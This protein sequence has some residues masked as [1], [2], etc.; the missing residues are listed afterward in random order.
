VLKLDEIVAL[1]NYEY[2]NSV[3]FACVKK[4]KKITHHC[5]FYTSLY[6]KNTAPYN[7]PPVYYL[8]EAQTFGRKIYLLPHCNGSR[9]TYSLFT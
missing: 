1:L 4:R 6:F 2:K 5:S 3:L 9:R 8:G 7:Y